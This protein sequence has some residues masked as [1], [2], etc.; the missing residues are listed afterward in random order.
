MGY[1][2]NEKVKT[3]GIPWHIVD[4]LRKF[5]DIPFFCETGTAG[6]MSIKEAAIK[7][8][9]L[10]TIEIIEGRQEVDESFDNI[11][12]LTGDSSKL[13]T[14][15]IDEI[16]KTKVEEV[17]QYVIFSLDAHYS[18]PTPNKSKIKECPLLD[19]IK[20]I[21]NYPDDSIV[22]ID[23]SRLFLGQVPWPN[24][25]K[26][27]PSIQQIFSLLDKTLPHNIHTLRDDY[28]LSYPDRIRDVFDK[29][30]RDNYLI[31]YPTAEMKLKS[32]GKLVWKSVFEY[33]NK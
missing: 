26:D 15:V 1:L 4:P 3:G 9:K 18:E 31:R 5:V 24:D 28:I 29:E 33:L 16:L 25:P 8:K 27:W 32:A 10:W 17:P 6:G 23:D 19:E 12:W 2:I 14:H 11:T 7:F 30:W 22:I 20:A 13:L 21:G